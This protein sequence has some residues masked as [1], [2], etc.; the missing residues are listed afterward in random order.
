MI[1]N[2]VLKRWREQWII[3][4]MFN[5]VNGYV[6]Y[7]FPGKFEHIFM[8]ERHHLGATIDLFFVSNLTVF[9]IVEVT[10]DVIACWKEEM[11][12]YSAV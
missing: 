1:Y 10:V 7:M 4:K 3:I 12:G 11:L 6:H 8:K 9:Q 5:I 2:E